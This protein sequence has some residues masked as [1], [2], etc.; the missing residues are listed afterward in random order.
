MK[1]KIAIT[2]KPQLPKLQENVLKRFPVLK[3]QYKDDI[4]PKVTQKLFKS[5]NYY[6]P[7]ASVANAVC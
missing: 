1:G 4:R 3:K 5:Y 7:K 2:L 6:I